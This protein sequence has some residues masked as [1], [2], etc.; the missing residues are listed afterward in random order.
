MPIPSGRDAVIYPQEKREPPKFTLRQETPQPA[1]FTQPLPAA[2]QTY[3]PELVPAK[4][5][6]AEGNSAFRPA[7]LRVPL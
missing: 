6:G 1:Q 3:M 2:E 7:G 5:P 4:K